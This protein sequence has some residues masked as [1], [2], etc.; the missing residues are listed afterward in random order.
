MILLPRDDKPR[1]RDSIRPIITAVFWA[2]RQV[3]FAE[4]EKI[5]FAFGFISWFPREKFVLPFDAKRREEGSIVK[6]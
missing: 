3:S 6:L 1:E 4:S 5:C 2:F